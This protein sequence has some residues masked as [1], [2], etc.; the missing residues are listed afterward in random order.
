MQNSFLLWC[1]KEWI[2]AVNLW[3]RELYLLVFYYDKVTEQMLMFDK[4]MGAKLASGVFTNDDGKKYR[5]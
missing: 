2:L 4:I 5:R 1:L 3:E